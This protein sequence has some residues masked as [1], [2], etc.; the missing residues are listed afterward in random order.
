MTTALVIAYLPMLHAAYATRE[1]PLST[2]DDG[3]AGPVTPNS[4]LFAW[5]PDANPS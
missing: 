5:S 4:L 1:R 3:S 2:L